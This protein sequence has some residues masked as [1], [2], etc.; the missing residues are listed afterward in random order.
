MAE[1]CPSCGE[2]RKGGEDEC[3]YCGAYVTRWETLPI[4]TVHSGKQK[5]EEPESGAESFFKA[6]FQ[7]KNLPTLIRLAA[8]LVIF[9]V[10][11]LSMLLEKL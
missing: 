2:E 4:L 8:L 10:L 11:S 3:E 9:L 1:Y 6:L 7:E 5:E